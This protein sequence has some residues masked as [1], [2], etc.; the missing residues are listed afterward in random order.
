MAQKTM[1]EFEKVAKT[2]PILGEILMERDL[3]ALVDQL[4][5]EELPQ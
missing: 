4:A 2:Y 1:Q 5:S 3:I